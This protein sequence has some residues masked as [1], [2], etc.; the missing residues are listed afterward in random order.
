MDSVL[1]NRKN[2]TDG[3]DIA[4]GISRIKNARKE[5]I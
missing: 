2:R 5:V 1:V 4:K 3:L